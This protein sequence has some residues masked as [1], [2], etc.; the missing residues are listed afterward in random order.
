MDPS[1]LEVIKEGY[2]SEAVLS[3]HH[4]NEVSKIVEPQV[5]DNSNQSAHGCVTC[6]VTDQSYISTVEEWFNNQNTYVSD[7][8]LLLMKKIHII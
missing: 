3:L 4:V 2:E 1:T 5:V 7:R 8:T 6:Y